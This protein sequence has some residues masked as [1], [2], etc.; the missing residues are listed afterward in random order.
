VGTPGSPDPGRRA[1]LT[2]LGLAALAGAGW[3]REGRGEDWPARPGD[4]Y[5]GD[6]ATAWFDH[7]LDVVRT[8][9]GFSPPVAAR[10]LGYAGIALYEA[11]VPGLPRHRSLAGQLRDLRPPPPAG[12][13][14]Y[15]WPTVASTALATLLRHLC[16]TA[17]AATRAQG[18]ALEAGQ[19]AAFR[20]AAPA[21]VFVR[22]IERGLSVADHVFAWSR[23]DGGHEGDR[24]PPVPYT[25]PSGPG[26]WVPTPPGFQPALLPTWGQNRAFVMPAERE[27]PAMPPVPYA[28]G[29]RSDFRAEALRVYRAV[30]GLTPEQRAIALF[31][32]DDPGR[33]VTPPGHS[34]SVLTQ[35]LRD[36]AAPL[37]VAA[38]AYAKVGI[39]VADAFIDCWRTKY[40]VNLL[41][42]VTYIRS[43]IDPDWM[44][45]LVTPPFPEH[46]SGHSVQS[47]ALAEVL[48]DLFGRVAFTDRTHEGRGLPARTF[49]SFWHAA[50]EAA[51][52][53]L[54]GGI[55]FL[56]AI[57]AG[58][59]Q[60][61]CIG[62]AVNALRT[63]V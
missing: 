12:T 59:E 18:L 31:W 63:R 1:L 15:H 32:S 26:L 21:S 57:V 10:A 52:S 62:R 3:T 58:V 13:H 27:C 49:T 39:A 51:M 55:H 46:T 20:S 11:I 45:L 28:T 7:A 42:P 47:A 35:V 14:A 17:P 56:G 8:T 36:I 40:R 23:T 25:P 19:L 30:T 22:S 5:P 41:R 50:R 2:G 61:R 33:T 60:G 6:V 44:P 29:D 53:R 38:E 16:P 48:T 9:P 24:R 34:V 54:Y 43:A 37:D 4:A